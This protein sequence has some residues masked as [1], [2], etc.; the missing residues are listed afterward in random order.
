MAT[1]SRRRLLSLSAG[2]GLAI[3]AGCGPTR[4]G[5][6][7]HGPA[8]LPASWLSQLPRTWQA[9]TVV[10]SR[11]VL[12]ARGADLLQLSD[13]WAT[14]TPASHFQALPAGIAPLLNRLDPIAAP[15]SRLLAPTGSAARAFPW[16]LG[17]WVLLVR[18]RPD[19]V[20]RAPEGWSLLLDP[21]LKGRLLLPSSP[22]V[23]ISLL[24]GKARLDQ[25]TLPE[26]L[27]RLRAQALAFDDV[28]GLNLLLA[29]DADAIVLPSQRVIPLLRRDPR[30]L[31]VQP[32]GGTPL[33]WSLLLQPAG[34]T[35]PL[36]LDWLAQALREPLLTRL[37]TEGWLPPLPRTRLEPL[38]RQQPT[39]IR[40]LLLPDPVLLD[41]CHTLAPL[42]PPER[43]RAQALWDAAG[44]A[45]P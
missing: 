20:A 19:L 29:G 3:L 2:G 16:A 36:P 5:T 42:T 28:D 6:L 10:G 23:V 32:A 34:A 33:I 8:T 14:T 40:S 15:I 21:S 41:R 39:M 12:D 31:A 24:A 43:A 25:P 35:M 9:R 4:R 27:R 11:E 22:R 13:G 44:P 38:L 26:Q 37:M 30:L 7:I 45:T 17:T 18:E 1:F